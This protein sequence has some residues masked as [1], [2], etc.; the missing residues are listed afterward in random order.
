MF[1]KNGNK[2]ENL[3]IQTPK[4]KN[5]SGVN[6]NENR[7]HIDFEFNP[8]KPDFY[9]FFTDLDEKL[10]LTVH[11]NSKNWFKQNFPLDVVDEF[12]KT[13]IKPGR[14]NKLP[15]IRFKIPV[16]KK[17]IKGEFYNYKREKITYENISE[18]QELISVIHII[19]MKFLKQQFILETQLIQCK[20]CKKAEDTNTLGYIINDPDSD[21]EADEYLIP[22]PEEIN[23]M[24][25][26]DDSNEIE[27]NQ[28]EQENELV[29]ENKELEIDNSVKENVTLEEENKELEIDNLVKENVTLE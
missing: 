21:Y 11:R 5:I 9:Q 24:N 22:L 17:E 10:I 4:L 18:E 20:V 23:E 26:Q 16:S 15:T 2:K 1:L 28:L 19:G 13:N 3:Y 27:S 7:A 14:N 6:L 12:Y 29:E 8:E 25:F